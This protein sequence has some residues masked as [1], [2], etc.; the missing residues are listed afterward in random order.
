MDDVPELDLLSV[1]KQRVA[2]AGVDAPVHLSLANAQ[3][4]PECVVLS[5]GTPKQGDVF[6]DFEEDAP[7]RVTVICRRMSELQ[8]M[9]DASSISEAIDFGS[10]DSGNGSYE[11]TNLEKGRPRPMPWDESGR[12]VWLFDINLTIERMAN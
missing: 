11:V 1:L 6:Y 7:V 9:M 12:W 5:F 3:K 4:V 2:D 8:S 10:L